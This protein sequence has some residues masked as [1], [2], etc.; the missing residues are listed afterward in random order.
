MKPNITTSV[1]PH[2]SVLLLKCTYLNKCFN[3][4]LSIFW[5]TGSPYSITFPAGATTASFNISVTDDN[6]LEDNEDIEVEIIVSSL[7]SRVGV[8]NPGQATVT[9][10]DDDGKIKFYNQVQLNMCSW[11]QKCNNNDVTVVKSLDY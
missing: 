6:I 9:I 4:K 10:V 8:S 2:D 7:P 1:L 3:V 5:F 11:V